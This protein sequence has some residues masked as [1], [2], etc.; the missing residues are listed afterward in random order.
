MLVKKQNITFRLGFRPK[1]VTD[2]NIPSPTN[3]DSTICDKNKTSQI[4]SQIS[5]V[6]EIYTVVRRRI[7]SQINVFLVVMVV[8][9]EAALQMVVNSGVV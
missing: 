7:P 3:C 8:D 1:Y 2:E 4:P 9:R 6:S 5:V